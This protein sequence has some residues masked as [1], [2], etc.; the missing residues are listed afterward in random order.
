MRRGGLVMERRSVTL[1]ERRK[2]SVMGSGSAVQLEGVRPE[3][4]I[5]SS[6]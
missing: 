1:N 2:W 6:V 3:Q 4:H 5:K